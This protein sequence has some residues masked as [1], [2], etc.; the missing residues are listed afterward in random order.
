VTQPSNA[1]T[2]AQLFRQHSRGVYAHVQTLVPNEHDAAEVFQ[3]TCQ[4]LWQKFD[5]YQPNTDFRAWACR[6]AYYKVLKLRERQFRSPQLFSAKFLELVDEELI[7]MSDVLDAR[8]EALARCREKLNS[9]DQDLLERFYREGATTR[10][11][12]SH[13]RKSVHQ[14]YRAVRRIHEALLECINKV[15]KEEPHG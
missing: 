10:R 6:I 8:S 15:L 14:V 13:L 2:F 7:V 5:Q 3:E 11:V 4:T 9:R 1:G 12:A